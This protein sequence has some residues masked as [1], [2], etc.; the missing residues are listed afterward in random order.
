MKG[1]FPLIV[2]CA[3]AAFF[4]AAAEETAFGQTA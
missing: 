2:S 3:V 4:S 1:L